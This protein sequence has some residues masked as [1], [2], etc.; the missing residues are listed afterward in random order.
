MTVMSA[1]TGPMGA[2][3][4]DTDRTGAAAT[5][6]ATAAA[7]A[8]AGAVGAGEAFG[9]AVRALRSAADTGAPVLLLAHVNPDGDS[10]GSA[11]ALGL[12]LRRLG[13]R[14]RVSF[15]AE[16]FVVPRTLRFLPGQDLLVA[17]GDLDSLGTAA[18]LVVTL[19]VGSEERLGRLSRR[20]A[21]ARSLVVDH[22]A[23]NTLF[24]EVN[25][26]DPEAASTSVL[27]TRI[28]DA[29]GA[30]L[31]RDIAAAVYTGLVTD[32]GSFRFAATT[33]AVHELAARLLAT[34]I[35]HDQICRTLWDTH[36]FGYL[37]LLGQTLERARLEP[38]LDLIW[39]WCT[40]SDL[41]LAG[42]GYDEIEAVIDTVRTV[43]EAEVALVCKQDG[44]IWKLSVRSK[45]AVDV[46]A[47]C[48]TLG[49]G[50]HRFAAGVSSSESLAATMDRFREELVHAPRLSR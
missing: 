4:G 5:V 1:G 27:V 49:G 13:A 30:E 31:D 19:D 46:G 9:A 47:L 2:G 24:G 29:L 7:G 32:T 12:A 3:T 43:S 35:R 44:G 18:A 38:E 11:I 40:E 42:I 41:R 16:P 21:G 36:R 50:G 25:F 34:G 48:T 23:S 15:D 8:G 39:T 10:L 20:L 22:H 6:G 28:I 14:P 45:G 37:K 26:V 33:P 17:P